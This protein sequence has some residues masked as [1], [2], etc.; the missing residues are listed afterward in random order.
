MKTTSR[1]VIGLIAIAGA[2]WD[3]ELAAASRAIEVGGSRSITASGRV[4]FG[5]ATLESS[6]ELICD[7]TL[8]R[9]IGGSIPKTAGTLFGK[10][11]GMAID[12]GAN[13]SEHCRHGSGILGI[14]DIV[15]LADARR[16]GTHTE[17]GAG[18]LLYAVTGG[19][20]ELWKL[21][22]DSFQGTLPRIEGV[23]VHITGIQFKFSRFL[24]IVGSIECL[25]E[26]SVFGLISINRETGAVVSA[27]AVL[28]RTS[29]RKIEGE[30]FC[31]EPSRF[32]GT[33]AVSPAVTIRLI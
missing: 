5:E 25:W 2:L 32:E 20:A 12:R 13:L 9:T 26:G 31:P 23:N 18:V 10:V 30:A 27:R 7:I 11:T 24:T 1:L 6:T 17:L 33:F 15:P 28:E 3:S 4:K 22:Y 16:P 14:S 21:I 19:R 29:L 8:L